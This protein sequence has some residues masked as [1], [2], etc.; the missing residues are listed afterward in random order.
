MAMKQRQISGKEKK[1][2]EK[3]ETDEK[4]WN[5]VAKFT[6]VWEGERKGV[7]EKK[8][9]KEPTTAITTTSLT[10]T[11]SYTYREYFEKRSIEKKL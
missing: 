11:H 1:K 4:S 6:Q 5:Y 9:K 8:K 2:M 10:G 3:R 7:R